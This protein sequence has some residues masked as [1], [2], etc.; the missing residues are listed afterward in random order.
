MADE[1]DRVGADDQRKIEQLDHVKR[2]VRDEVHREIKERTDRTEPED[3]Q[4]VAGVAREIKHRAVQEVAASEAELGRAR[5][6][7]RVSQII[8][9]LFYV[10]SALIGLQT[11]LELLA[12]RES[13][14]FKQFMNAITSPF[15]APFKGLMADPSMGSSQLMLSYVIALVVYVL[16]HL[17]INGALR[18][19]VSKKTEV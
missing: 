1:K 14:G 15:L 5:T 3:R 18:L 4:Q 11:V 7:A 2:E 17:A 6:G 16:L 10:L 12:V 8:D 19:L 9:Y 13:S